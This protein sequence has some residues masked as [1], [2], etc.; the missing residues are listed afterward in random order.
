MDGWMDDILDEDT[1]DRFYVYGCNVWNLQGDKMS[2]AK[3]AIKL[4]KQ[5]FKDLEI[6]TTLTEVNID[7]THFEDMAKKAC[8]ANGHIYGFKTLNVNDVINIYKKSL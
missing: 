8:Y 6:P 3:E 5:F 4:T 1:L 7:E 2:V